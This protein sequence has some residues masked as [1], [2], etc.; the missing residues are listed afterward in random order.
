MANKQQPTDK[1]TCCPLRNQVRDTCQMAGSESRSVKQQH[2]NKTTNM[3]QATLYPISHLIKLVIL[4]LLLANLRQTTH[5]DQKQLQTQPPLQ[6]PSLLGQ[7]ARFDVHQLFGTI[8][9]I[10]QV[11]MP[12]NIVAVYGKCSSD[13]RL[14][15]EGT[16]V[17]LLYHFGWHMFFT[18]TPLFYGS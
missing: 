14:M 11:L 10:Q 12:S 2:R 13:T 3:A 6:T 5:D 18:L 17:W 7:Q 16:Q 9:I 15:L 1:A 8:Q 4:Q